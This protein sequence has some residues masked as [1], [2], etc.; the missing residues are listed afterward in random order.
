MVGGPSPGSAQDRPGS[1]Q[2]DLTDAGAKF[3]QFAFDESGDLHLA[4]ADLLADLALGRTLVEA[5]VE[6]Q[7]VAPLQGAGDV[8]VVPGLN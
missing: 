2:R 7:P 4:N 5:Q 3:P 8:L 6:D 1:M